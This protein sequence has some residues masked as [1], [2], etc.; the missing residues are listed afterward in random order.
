MAAAGADL[1]NW[2]MQYDAEQLAEFAKLSNPYVV[3]NEKGVVVR[4]DGSEKFVANSVIKL[5]PSSKKTKRAESGNDLLA[6]M[7]GTPAP[8]AEVVVDFRIEFPYSIIYAPKPKDYSS[9]TGWAG[10]VIVVHNTP[11]IE[12]PEITI[13]VEGFMTAKEVRPMSHGFRL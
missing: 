11:D 12:K 10:D 3:I 7:R 6:A 5:L 1:P 2:Q 4:V 9:M 13:R 8:D